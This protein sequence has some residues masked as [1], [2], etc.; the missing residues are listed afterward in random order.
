[1]NTGDE[2]PMTTSY[3]DRPDLVAE[4][5]IAP[6]VAELLKPAK[7]RGCRAHAETPMLKAQIGLMLDFTGVD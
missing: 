2:L 5:I 7:I 6:Q 4:C 3:I 1:M